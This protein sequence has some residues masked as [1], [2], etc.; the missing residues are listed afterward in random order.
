LIPAN[1]DQFTPAKLVKVFGFL[2]SY[3]EPIKLAREADDQGT[4]DL[5][6]KYLKWNRAT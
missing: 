2:H 1:D 3:N 5:L 6:P 4:I